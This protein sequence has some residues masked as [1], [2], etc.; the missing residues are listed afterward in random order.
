MAI[1]QRVTGGSPVAIIEQPVESGQPR[2]FWNAAA[3]P[4]AWITP[5]SGVQAPQLPLAPDPF[6]DG[7]WLLQ[8][9]TEVSVL[10]P[11]K[12][13]LVTIVDLASALKNGNPFQMSINVVAGDDGG[14]GISG[15]PIAIPNGQYAAVG[16]FV[17]NIVFPPVPSPV[18]P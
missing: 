12:V 2:L 16:S 15:V 5:A 13:Y 6:V 3:S 8:I 1:N 11:N 18:N 17:G 7:Q 4:P 10:W 14:N 9:P